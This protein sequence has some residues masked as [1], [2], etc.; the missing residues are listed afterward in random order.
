MSNVLSKAVYVASSVSHGSHS[1]TLLFLL[2][3]NYLPIAIS[4]C[5]ILMYADDVK[6]FYTSDDDHGQAVLQRNI[7]LFET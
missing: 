7:D 2:F 1:G 4:D 3:L 6:L 5:N